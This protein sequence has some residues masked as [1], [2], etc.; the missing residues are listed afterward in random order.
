MRPVHV[1]ISVAGATLAT[2]AALAGIPAAAA[3]ATP[4]GTGAGITA[5]RAPVPRLFRANSITWISPRRGWVLGA[6][7]C[8]A[9]T[10][11]DVIATTDGGRHWHFITP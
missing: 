6:A 1:M 5:A 10:C 3:T 2:A 9:K 8:G 4:P 11:T 7:P